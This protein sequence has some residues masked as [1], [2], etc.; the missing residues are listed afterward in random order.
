MYDIREGLSPKR[1]TIAMWCLSWIWGHYKG[2]S[3]EDFDKATDELLE[4]GFNTIRI[5]CFP[6]IIGELSDED[7]EITLPAQPLATWG[8]SDR[9]VRHKIIKELVEIMELCK[10]KGIYVILST[11]CFACIEFPSD[12]I[13]KNSVERYLTNWEK[14]LS[15]LKDKNLLDNVVYVDLDQEFPFFSPFQRDIVFLGGEIDVNVPSMAAAMEEAGRQVLSEGLIWNSAQLRFVRD[16]MR[17]SIIRMQYKFPELRFTFSLTQLWNEVKTL[18][19]TCF[20]VLELHFFISSNNLG[21]R[22]MARTGFTQLE[23]D[24]ENR[25]YSDYQDRIDKTFKAVRPMLLGEM[26]NQLEFAQRW[27]REAAAPVVNTESWGPWWHMDHKDL[28]W[29]WLRAWC[30]ECN[31]LAAGYGL[32]G[33]TPWNF[34]H[35]YWENWKDVKWYREVNGCFMNG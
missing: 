28:D 22:F 4:R 24:R 12:I 27:G 16:L 1:L 11:W 21:D 23:K 8:V 30:A 5:E 19:L 20:D 10:R 7:C 26:H 25:S 34:C 18:G 9:T 33:T 31:A 29:G 14:T 6:Q 35:P 32:W 13:R 17:S 3:Y 15:I 2:G